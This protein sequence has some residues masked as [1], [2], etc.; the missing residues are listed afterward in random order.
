MN[1][2][3]TQVDANL[4][5]ELNARAN[6]A[7][8]RDTNSLNFML[9]KI[10]NVELSAYEGPGP[11]VDE[12]KRIHI[13]GGN[14]IWNRNYL[15]Y[16][17]DG[18]LNS[19]KTVERP[20][21]ELEWNWNPLTKTAEPK[22]GKIDVPN[23]QRRIPPYISSADIQIG[24]NSMGLLNTANVV[25]EI[26]N[27][28]RDL[29]LME[30]LYMRPG[31]YVKLMFIHDPKTLVSVAE[32]QG[33]LSGSIPSDVKLRSLYPDINLDDKKTEIRRMNQIVFEGL[34]TNFNFSYQKDFSVQLQISL[35]G[36]SNVFTDVSM[37]IDAQGNSP[38]NETANPI[39]DPAKYNATL[40]FNSQDRGF[41][42]LLTNP[43]A[44]TGNTIQSVTPTNNISSGRKFYIQPPKTD[45]LK[46]TPPRRSFYDQLFTAVELDYAASFKNKNEQSFIG[47]PGD[48]NSNTTN[49]T[50]PKIQLNR[51]DKKRGTA[52]SDQYFLCGNAW[53]QTT[54]TTNV[55]A[56]DVSTFQ[57][58]ITLGYLIDFINEHVLRE[59]IAGKITGKIV[60]NAQIICSDK[61]CYS[62]YYPE[63]C[64]TDPQNILLL[65]A[66]N[67]RGTTEAYGTDAT[68]KIFFK[69]TL[70]VD[71]TWEGFTGNLKEKTDRAYPSRI[72]INLDL[73]NDILDSLSA[74]DPTAF[75]VSDFLSA[76]SL[77]ISNATSKAISLKLITH[78]EDQTVL[79][80]YDENFIGTPEDKRGV[81]PYTIPMTTT[82]TIVHDFQLKASLPDNVASLSY[83]LNQDPSRITTEDIGPYINYMYNSNDPTKV[84]EAKQLHVNKHLEFKNALTLAK[85]KFAAT[86]TDKNLQTALDLAQKNYL[87]RPTTDLQKDI[88]SI[89][90]IIP[91]DI[92]FTI[93]GIQGFRYGDVL[94]FDVLPD[95]YKINTVFSIVGV[96]H[97]V[98][99]DSTWTT[100][101]RC[102]MRPKVNG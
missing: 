83:V 56:T 41:S 61:F 92:T 24:D 63:L 80:F 50:T 42:G 46:L 4:Q 6:S 16:G 84:S 35:R 88:Q 82:G 23:P 27:A 72:L 74:G 40:N 10:A 33:L 37:F 28:E 44:N 78:P 30:E 89:A 79:A 54:T 1:I 65:P 51:L 85:S 57:R 38:G 26:P 87:S 29:N 8:I 55:A 91:F 12:S 7:F 31:R 17:Q 99:Q 36:T 18:F 13:L 2:F 60:N 67:K 96:N 32:T 47:P 70:S 43:F 100:E 86:M 53:P 39:A 97:Q 25:I 34:L 75:K 71:N 93:D 102:I 94:T 73:I 101:I 15:A 62:V 19:N 68:Q 9:G 58:Y 90:P 77:Q 3:Y 45:L 20:A 48:P 69:D 21:D 98:S 5:K 66:D 11:A 52:H 76:I 49:S 64:S 59:T 22:E 14:Q 95:K 81:E